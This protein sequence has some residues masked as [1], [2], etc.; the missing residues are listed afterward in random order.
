MRRTAFVLALTAVGVFFA[1]R[2][3]FYALLLYLWIAYFRP[4]EWVWTDLIQ[5]LN[6]SLLAG[7][8]LG[9]VTLFSGVRHRFNGRIALILLFLLQT[10]I[11]LVAMLHNDD[12]WSRWQDFL[13]TTFITY[14]IVVLVT[15][16][17]RLRLALLIMTV[18]LAFEPAKQAWAQ[19]ILNPGGK[20]F[21]AIG[22]LGDE[23]GVGV[24]MLMLAP[25]LGTL[26]RTSAQP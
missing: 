22:F 20:N 24:G 10:F 11:P 1:L 19:F 26:A 15:D 8:Y 14:L 18:S 25:L 7:L 13:K 23:S 17:Q 16:R 4:Q 3:P 5:R 9:A 21:N 12:L 6:L 2:G